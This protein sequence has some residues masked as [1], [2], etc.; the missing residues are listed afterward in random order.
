MKK[1]SAF[2][3]PVQVSVRIGIPI[4]T[5]GLTIDDRDALIERVRSEV[6]RLRAMP[7]L[8]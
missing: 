1:G 5:A 3:R 8:W 7:S 2:V 6:E 4:P